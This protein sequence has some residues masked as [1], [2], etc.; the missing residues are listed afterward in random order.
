MLTEEH[1]EFLRKKVFAHL[2]VVDEDGLPHSTVVWVDVEDDVVLMNTALGRVK[3]R[4]LQPGAPVALS[5][6]DPGNP[7]RYLGVRGRVAER[8][9]EDAPAVIDAL[10]RKYT[11]REIF[12]G[13]RD[14]R[15]TIAIKPEHVWLY[16]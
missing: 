15:V 13:R 14:D 12:A 4:L 10:S 7:Y 6:T 9:L 1:R 11:D 2:A 16:G 8:R 5:A 3:E